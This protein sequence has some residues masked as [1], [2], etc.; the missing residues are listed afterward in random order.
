MIKR[1]KNSFND[2]ENLG[3]SR[4]RIRFDFLLF[5]LVI[6]IASFGVLMIYSATRETLPGGVTDP[7]NYLKKQLIG[8][9]AG[10]VI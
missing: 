4:R 3:E 8:M 2:F 9:A 6:A 5:F 10:I 1:R 7:Q